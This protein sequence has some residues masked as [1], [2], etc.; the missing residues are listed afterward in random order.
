MQG[1]ESYDGDAENTTD[2]SDLSLCSPVD[3]FEFTD[4]DDL[5]NVVVLSPKPT[6]KSTGK[7]KGGSVVKGKKKDN[8][9]KSTQ[10]ENVNVKSKRKQASSTK[11]TKDATGAKKEL[12]QTVKANKKPYSCTQGTKRKAVV[13]VYKLFSPNVSAI[14][15]CNSSMETEICADSGIFVSPPPPLKKV[16][17]VAKDTSTPTNVP[18]AI[19]YK[20]NCF[21]FSKSKSPLSVISPISHQPTPTSDYSSMSS[22]AN[23]ST[24][25][26]SATREET[27]SSM[28]VHETGRYLMVI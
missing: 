2:A 13:E 18:Q 5:E 10:K 25:S 22:I 21:G 16:K 8:K 17:L 27:T 15:V 11:T 19:H 23:I 14:S 20:D 1:V 26:P 28:E 4:S 9:P 12:P 6:N 3:T 7:K 24:I